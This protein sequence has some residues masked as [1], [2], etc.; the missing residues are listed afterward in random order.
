MSTMKQPPLTSPGRQRGATLLVAM[1]FLIVLM[2]VVASAIKVTN[3][4]TRLAGNTQTQSEAF[5]AA[6]QAIEQLISTDFTNPS[7]PKGADGNPLPVTTLVNMMAGVNDT[8]QAGPATYVIRV[9]PQ[10]L[11]RK[12]ITCNDLKV[13]LG[14]TT[15]TVDQ[16]PTSAPDP[17]PAQILQQNAGIEIDPQTGGG[18][19]TPGADSG[20]TDSTPPSSD[21]LTKNC[22]PLNIGTDSAYARAMW[23]IKAIAWPPG[24]ND[25]ANPDP[26]KPAFAVLNQG[27]EL[28]TP[29][30][31]CVAPTP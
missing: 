9:V 16:C 19:S 5:S 13:A 31:A 6:Q 29:T 11:S 2:L 10:L 24:F 17:D 27:V 26:S 20:S 8:T 1:I 3:I 23:N 4:N 18:A 15:L 14:V 28:L 21:D 12:R 7:L 25:P 30:P 22:L